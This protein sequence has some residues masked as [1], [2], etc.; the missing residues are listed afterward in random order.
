MQRFL[1]FSIH[2]CAKYS[3]YS[4]RQDLV[5]PERTKDAKHEIKKHSKYFHFSDTHHWTVRA[6]GEIH[7]RE[8]LKRNIV[9][10]SNGGH[11][12]QI[13]LH[14]ERMILTTNR[15][16]TG[17]LSGD[18]LNWPRWLE[19]LSKSPGGVHRK[20]QPITR[21]PITHNDIFIHPIHSLTN[22]A[23]SIAA[24]QTPISC[25]RRLTQPST[26]DS[27]G[28]QLH[29]AKCL[30]TF[31]FWRCLHATLLPDQSD[32]LNRTPVTGPK[33]AMRNT[34]IARLQ[35]CSIN[36]SPSKSTEVI[37]SS[38]IDVSRQGCSQLRCSVWWNEQFFVHNRT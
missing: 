32:S 24:L 28:T 36:D 29:A 14:S 6:K 37:W 27:I 8:F 19:K 7:R 13:F 31:D 10:V 23:T 30:L 4:F 9:N 25:D 22:S 11:L 12:T 5:P 21:E 17:T 15:N 34:I 35:V 38:L 1:N 26:T 33:N 2:G 18:Q 3:L 20:Q 16:P